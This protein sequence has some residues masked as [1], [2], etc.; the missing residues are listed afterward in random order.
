M[1]ASR[2]AIEAAKLALGVSVKQ[3]RQRAFPARGFDLTEWE[4]RKEKYDPRRP[5]DVT[6][7]S[8]IVVHVTA[9]RGGF[10]V[11]RRRVAF[12]EKCLRWIAEHRSANALVN[13]GWSVPDTVL[14]QLP[15]LQDGPFT[16]MQH[17][18]A[19]KIHEYAHRLALWERYREV[20][21]HQVGAANGD[22]IANQYLHR[23]TYH[24]GAGNIGVGWALD[25]SHKETLSD[26]MIDTGRASLRSLIARVMYASE[27]R[28]VV[29]VPHRAFSSSRRL[30]TSREVWRHVVEPVVS[31]QQ[32]I[33]TAPY[34]VRI[35]YNMAVGKGRPVPFSWSPRANHDDR[36]R[37]LR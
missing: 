13:A 36:G 20:P 35:D 2:N 23:R 6:G 34:E 1:L 19:S 22:N 12:F 30:D 37:P 25:V 14:G 28:D 15:G 3:E 16:T 24:A 27:A 26:F 11:S 21:Y 10:G 17:V 33:S 8:V 5:H 29:V 9:V 31:A 18:S 4:P 32:A 7:L